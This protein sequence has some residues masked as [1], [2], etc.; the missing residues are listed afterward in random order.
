M[1]DPLDLGSNVEMLCPI[2]RRL[3]NAVLPVTAVAPD[4]GGGS[5]IPGVGTCVHVPA[6]GWVCAVQAPQ[7][8][9]RPVTPPHPLLPSAQGL[10]AW[11][12][13][14][15]PDEDLHKVRHMRLAKPCDYLLMSIK[16]ELTPPPPA[17]CPCRS[18]TRPR[19]APRMRP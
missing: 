12:A 4:A 13:S 11:V 10:D 14:S 3:F 1:R 17:C 6:E 7:P 19:C 18:H 15:Q 2:C 9:L 5:A 16:L 8:Q